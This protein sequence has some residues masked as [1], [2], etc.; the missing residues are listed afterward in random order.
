MKSSFF[1]ILIFFF[2]YWYFYCCNKYLFYIFS[3]DDLFDKRR[4]LSFLEY[5]FLL[6]LLSPLPSAPKSL[7]LAPRGT[8][9]ASINLQLSE[10]LMKS[11][12]FFKNTSNISVVIWVFYASFE[13]KKI[14]KSV[15]AWKLCH[16][17]WWLKSLI[18]IITVI[19]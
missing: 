11:S 17:M 16:G 5:F 6:W 8:Q 19:F 14:R 7:V 18:S 13:T 10:R 3:D 15:L 12:D 9:I 2:L 4:M 1:F